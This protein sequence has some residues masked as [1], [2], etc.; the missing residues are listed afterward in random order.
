MATDDIF[1]LFQ[2]FGRFISEPAKVIFKSAQLGLKVGKATGEIGKE[3]IRGV[4]EGTKVVGK[5]I[6]D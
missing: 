5:A 6:I 2:G 1:D 4:A 3:V